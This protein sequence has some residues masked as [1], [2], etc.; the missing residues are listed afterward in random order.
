MSNDPRFTVAERFEDADGVVTPVVN[1]AMRPLTDA[2]IP[3]EWRLK[4]VM[5]IIEWRVRK[6]MAIFS[7]FVL[8]VR[9]S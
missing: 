9:S 5:L 2:K 8:D 4:A 7:I 6:R 3:P 1:S